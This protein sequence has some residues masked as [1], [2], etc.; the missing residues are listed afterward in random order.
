MV[1][2]SGQAN[3]IPIGQLGQNIQLYQT[4]HNKCSNWFPSTTWQYA[5]LL[6]TAVTAFRY[7][8]GGIGSSARIIL[9]RKSSKS[10]GLVA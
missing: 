9:P 5:N 1:C 4:I 10:L 6:E 2:E 7:V 8:S 3:F